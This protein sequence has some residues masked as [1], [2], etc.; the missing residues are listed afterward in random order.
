M[1]VVSA[2]AL[3]CQQVLN[4]V[5]GVPSAI[6]IVEVFFLPSDPAT[7]EPPFPPLPM[8]LFINVRF[9]G[10]DNDPHS[11]FFTLVRPDGSS[12]TIPIDENRVAASKYKET[13]KSI[14]AIGRIG[15]EPKELGQHNILV[16]VDGQ[17]V[18]KAF[19]TLIEDRTLFE[20]QLQAKSVVEERPL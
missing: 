18:A 4:E 12:K 6:R 13:D 1:A 8:C 15:V 19:F 16:H 3:V 17:E 11:L 14:M 9:T 2:Y 7:V 10:D 20:G 5:D